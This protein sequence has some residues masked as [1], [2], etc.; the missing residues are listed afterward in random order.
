M[1][2]LGLILLLILTNAVFS[3]SSAF[4]DKPAATCW[5]S[6]ETPH[7]M[8]R[9]AGRGITNLGLGWLELVYQPYYLRA[10]GN[11][12]PVALVGGVI[13]GLVYGVA[14]TFVGVYDTLTFPFPIP[15]G[16]MPVMY[17]EIAIPGYCSFKHTERSI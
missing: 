5:T 6:P 7:T 16:Y 12:I 9:K 3:P 2:S 14:R 1:K 4:A 11:Q 15:E 13:K 8:W 17:P 10:E